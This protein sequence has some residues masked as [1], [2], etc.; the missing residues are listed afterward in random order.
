MEKLL[1][2]TFL[3]IQYNIDI[4]IH[5]DILKSNI[6]TTVILHKII[7]LIHEYISQYNR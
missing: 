5:L 6:N 3:F 2:N 1:L 7:E 4:F